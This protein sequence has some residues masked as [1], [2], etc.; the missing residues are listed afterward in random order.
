MI[1]PAQSVM[2]TVQGMF[3]PSA[4]VASTEQKLIPSSPITEVPFLTSVPL[5]SSSYPKGSPAP[6]ITLKLNLFCSDKLTVN[7]TIRRDKLDNKPFS[8]HVEVP[9]FT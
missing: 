7:K 2:R 5:M 3:I 4:T 9:D 1:L 6:P 8:I